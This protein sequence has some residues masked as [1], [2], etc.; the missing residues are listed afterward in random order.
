MG[1]PLGL[2]HLRALTLALLFACTLSAHEIGTTTVHAMFGS[3][4][5]YTIEVLTPREP[6]LRKLRGSYDVARLASAGHVRFG[7]VEGKPKVTVHPGDGNDVTVRYAGE[8]PRN[9]GSFTWQFDL[10]YTTYSLTIETPRGI[11]RREWVNGDAPSQPFPLDRVLPRSKIFADY[12]IL[13]FTHILPYGLDHILFVLG[14]LLLSRGLKPVLLQVTA[15]TVAHSITLAL[16]IYGI[17]ELSSRIVEPLIALS[18]AYVAVEN[19]ASRRV[20]SWR[21]VLVFV[22]GLLHGLGFAGVLRELGLPRSEAVT[23]LVAF[24]IGVELGQIA[25][26]AIAW[27]L[28]LRWT[29]E[30]DWYRRRVLV[31]ASVAIAAM[32]VF[33]MIERI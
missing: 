25:V 29:Q 23:G 28:V 6:L 21:I 27:A 15:F 20:H 4:Q 16:T 24:N 9:A 14:M 5:S 32:G 26:I 33:W 7:D 31:P 13:G 19:I 10:S 18:I 8:I 12:V 11:A 2:A 3:D 30:R 17:V 1:K 22:F